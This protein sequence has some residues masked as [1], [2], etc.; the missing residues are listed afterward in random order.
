MMGCRY[1]ALIKLIAGYAQSGVSLVM[2]DGVQLMPFNNADDIGLYYLVPL[3]VTYFSLSLDQALYLLLHGPIYIGAV[4]S[5]ISLWILYPSCIS[6]CTSLL[7]VSAITFIATRVLDV[8]CVSAAAVLLIVPLFLL[9]M[10]RVRSL[11]VMSTLLFYFGLLA[12]CAN[13]LRMH[14]GTG[15]IIFMVVLLAGAPIWQRKYKL[16]L[17]SILFIGMVI[18]NLFFNQVYRHYVS[19]TQCRFPA[20]QVQQNQ[21]VFWHS[22]YVGFGFLHNEYAIIPADEC[23]IARVGDL[24]ANA[25]YTS[26]KYENVLKDEIVRLIRKHPLFVLRTLFAKLGVLF[27]YLLICANVG[28]VAAW[29]FPKPWYIELSFWAALGFNALPGILALPY[30]GYLFGFIAFAILYG[31]VSINDALARFRN[32]RR[33]QSTER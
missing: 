12:G 13:A 6:R 28:L 22:I 29:F 23:A 24:D 5:I 9:S 25:V 30:Y 14:A 21:H 3:L 19:Y 8:Y 10:D 32:T 2:H 16:F 26:Q 31:I 20:H 11:Y 1:K 7:G 17:V 33:I 4:I 15:V 27:M 18:P